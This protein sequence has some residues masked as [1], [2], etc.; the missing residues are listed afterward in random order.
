METLGQSEIP[1]CLLQAAQSIR[2]QLCALH[3]LKEC[4][5]LQGG[6]VQAIAK[7]F[8]DPDS[9]AARWIA[10]KSTP[11][12]IDAPI[13][14][15]GFFPNADPTVAADEVDMWCHD[16]NHASYGENREGADEILRKELQEGWLAWQPNDAALEA[17]HGPATYSRIGVVKEVKDE[18]IKLRLIHDLR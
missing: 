10:E 5:G 11:L 7:A 4:E 17:E 16:W 15:N 14:P 9:E 2:E 12:G 6:L 8:G 18:K 3:E 13:V 1:E